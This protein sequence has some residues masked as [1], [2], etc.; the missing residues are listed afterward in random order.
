MS[1]ARIFCF[2]LFTPLLFWGQKHLIEHTLDYQRGQNILKGST[3]IS[4]ATQLY[5]DSILLH[6]P[7]KSLEL[8]Q[9]YYN[10]QLAQ[11]QN[12]KAF[13]AKRE[14]TGWLQID[15]LKINGK[16]VTQ[17]I[18][19][20]FNFLALPEPNQDTTHLIIY[21]RLQLPQKGLGPTGADLNQA[22]IIDWLPRLA[23]KEAGQWQA[24]PVNYFNDASLPN[25]SFR[26]TIG[27]ENTLKPICNLGLAQKV[28]TLTPYFYRYSFFGQ[29]RN[30][31]LFWSNYWHQF[32][33]PGGVKVYS[34]APSLLLEFKLREQAKTIS[35]FFKSELNDSLQQAKQYVYLTEKTGEYQSAKLLT[36][37]L[38][39]SLFEMAQDLAH[40]RAQAALRYHLHPNGY[41]QPWLARGLPYFYKYQFI[42][43]HFPQEYWVPFSDTWL[44]SLFD[45]DAFD[46]AYQNQFLYLF[47]ARQGLDQAA[48]TPSDSLS[49]LNYEGIAQAKTF[50][51]FNHLRA[52]LGARNFKRGMARY[53][54]LNQGKNVKTAA[55]KEALEYYSNKPLNWFF[56]E[57]LHTAKIMD[58]QLVKTSHCPTVTT[59]TVRNRGRLALPYSLTG[60]KN[61]SAIITE[62][63]TGHEGTRSVQLYQ[64]DFDKVVL[65]DHLLNSEYRQK[66]NRYY[67]KRWFLK[68]AEPLNF[69]F[70]NSFEEPQS[71]QI[72]YFP[73]VS[74]NAYDQVL[75]GLN[76]S[77][78]SI[79][80][81]KPFEYHLN[82]TFSTGTQR[83]T[84]SASARWNFTL[85]KSA[86]FRQITVGAYGRYFHYDQDLSFLRLSP[87]VNFRIRKP[88]PK[89][90]LI[91]SLRLRT[92]ILNREL[93]ANATPTAAN[94][95]SYTVANAG[96]HLENTNI[97]KP[98]IFDFNLEYSPQF[99]K[100]HVQ[101]DQRYM[102]PNKK[103]L[104]LRFFAGTFLHNASAE[105]P[106]NFYRFGL[107]GTPDYL[108]DYYL[109]GRS[110]TR[111][112]WS[113]Q[114]F[115]TDGGFK[116]QTNVF[117]NR[118]ML[119][120]NLSVPLYSF[121]GLFG[122]VAYADGQTYWDYGLRLAFLTDFLELYLPVQN[123]D[124]LFIQ[125]A[126]YL[127]NLRFVLDLDL[128][129]IINRLRRGY[130]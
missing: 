55:L 109:I 32:S 53:W 44:G 65:N 5:S 57:G 86:F 37:A 111:G 11:F 98:T 15:S 75:L 45:L 7:A 36:L 103:W 51:L 100:V 41:R 74:Y 84:G 60:Y 128:G 99:S 119:S 25:D 54:A 105:S 97:F 101:L 19:L 18:N 40:A 31:Q 115:T 23:Q 121:V 52:Y 130:Y 85:P 43:A 88:Y 16:P 104:I 82:P 122:D 126:N 127:S 107:S 26:L 110:D 129:N 106:T 87:T 76:L 113:R 21:Y 20:E 102:L 30:L 123:Q 28:D 13:Y 125:E 35:R 38:P 6:L 120:H 56:K 59:A 95:A 17:P 29:S 58:Y 91:Q 10:Q 79:L 66:N 63:F 9:S 108:F 1:K 3:R 33:L 89:S 114:F 124:R 94:E 64:E 71:T 62:W 61:G 83:L 69:A 67:P 47:L 118:Y 42:K 8:K 90:P 27:L 73:S 70:Y 49:R 72:F 50:L 96:Y 22:E 92:V 14:A 93:A 46:Y 112:L 80:V 4:L 117:A 2:L 39:S 68:R 77:N 81:Q 78:T 12:V 48:A 34:Q 24:N 116:S